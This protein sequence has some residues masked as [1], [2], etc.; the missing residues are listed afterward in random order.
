MIFMGHFIHITNQEEIEEAN[1]RHGEFNMIVEAD[2]AE[3]ALRMFRDRIINYRAN[4]DFFDGECAVY[5]VQL[6]EFDRFPQ[7][8]AMML[9]YKS[10]AGDPLMPFIG[11]SIPS[12][13]TD[14][15]RIFDWN[16]NNPEVDGEREKLFIRFGVDESCATAALADSQA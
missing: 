15:C 8:S 12:S 16:N 11:C 10:I 14:A 5:L 9:N 1:R 3:R 7:H 6:F 2:V 13:D 4:S